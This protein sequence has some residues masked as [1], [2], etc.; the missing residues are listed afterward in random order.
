INYPTFSSNLN[1]CRIGTNATL[2]TGN[3][4]LYRET[5]LHGQMSAIYIFDEALGSSQIQ[6]IY[7][8]G[9]N[10]IGTFE[11]EDYILFD[12]SLHHVFNG[13]LS[14]KLLFN[15][16]AKSRRGNYLM[17]N[18]TTTNEREEAIMLSST[19]PCIIHNMKNI[20]GC[21]VGIKVLFPLFLEMDQ[22]SNSEIADALHPYL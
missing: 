7:E 8:L 17:N 21:L 10:Y 20:I 13:N 3:Y 2:L 9:P 18:A 19:R 22:L 16:N 15:F 5:P 6:S 4:K 11:K 1:L 14:S 12:K